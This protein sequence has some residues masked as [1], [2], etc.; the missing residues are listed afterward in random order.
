MKTEYKFNIVFT[1]GESKF[2]YLDGYYGSQ[3]LVGISQSLLIAINAFLN[4]Q[5]ITQARAAKG[6]H[7]SFETSKR[8]SLIQQI[9]LTITDPT[10]HEVLIAL[11]INGIY[12]LLKWSILNGVGITY[13]S[14]KKSVKGII[15]TLRSKNDDLHEKLDDALLRAHQP[16]KYQGLNIIVK[17]NQTEIVTFNK[18]T[19]DFLETEIVDNEVKI[20]DAFVTRFNVLTGTGRLIINEYSRSIPFYP[21]EDL[22]EDSKIMLAENL[23]KVSRGEF[24]HIR[25]FVS[26]ITSKD[27]RLK[28][29]NLH[30]IVEF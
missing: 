14:T 27:G 3:S 30:N 2:D 28:R 18:S 15:K 21:V 7:L 23:A 10:L 17:L 12:D 5:I 13:N 20:I 26:E 1:D 8:G 24:D 25:F 4:R 11:E 19:L 22:E 29:Y 6:F 16:I 9:Y